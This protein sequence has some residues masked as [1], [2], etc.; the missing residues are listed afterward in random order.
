MI[1][2]DSDVLINYLIVQNEE[3][4]KLATNLYQEAARIKCFSYPCCLYRKFPLSFPS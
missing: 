3:K 4:H 2:F 1:Y